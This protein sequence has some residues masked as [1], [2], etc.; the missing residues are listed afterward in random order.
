VLEDTHAPDAFR[1]E[2][3]TLPSGDSV[4]I[5]PVPLRAAARQ[6]RPP[7]KV[8]VTFENR[9]LATFF[10]RGRRYAVERAYG[11]WLSGGDWWSQTLWGQEQWDLVAQAQDG[12][13]LCCC[14]MRDLMQGSW[15]MAALYD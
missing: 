6:I 11:P 9:H 13:M 7:E 5:S 3:F 12:S 15:Q 4:A 2:P 10:F 1:M 8:A 14:L